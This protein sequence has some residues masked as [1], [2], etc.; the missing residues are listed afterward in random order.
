MAMGRPEKENARHA[1]NDVHYALRRKSWGPKMKRL[2]GTDSTG[3]PLRTRWGLRG[4]DA[5]RTDVTGTKRHCR[6][7]EK[8]EEVLYIPAGSYLC[9]N[10]HP[11]GR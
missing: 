1:G 3:R 4:G 8:Y 6:E 9:D 11:T 5:C 2:L 7:I 10:F